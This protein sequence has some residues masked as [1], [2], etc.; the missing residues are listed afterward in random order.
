MALCLYRHSWKTVDEGQIRWT[1]TNYFDT[2]YN[3]REMDRDCSSIE[4]SSMHVPLCNVYYCIFVCTL[5]GSV[6]ICIDSANYEENPRWR[7][8]SILII[9]QFSTLRSYPNRRVMRIHGSWNIGY[10]R[11]FIWRK[12]IYDSIKSDSMFGRRV[13]TLT[14]NPTWRNM[15]KKDAGYSRGC[16]RQRECMVSM[17]VFFVC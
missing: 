8:R 14:H 5:C 7:E 4:G 10:T 9:L 2:R 1:E 17:C 16:K 6:V 15:W 12:I 13:R 11:S 3:S